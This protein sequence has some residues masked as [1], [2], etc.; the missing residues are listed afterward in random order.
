MRHIFL[1][2]AI[3]AVAVSVDCNKVVNDFIYEDMAGSTPAVHQPVEAN[4][5]RAI[6]RTDPVLQE[7]CERYAEVLQNCC[8]YSFNEA[9]GTQRLEYLCD[10]GQIDMSAVEDILSPE[11]FPDLTY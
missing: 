5:D 11:P 10:T 2:L 9:G 7:A 1:W 6:L 4:S 3:V 8:P